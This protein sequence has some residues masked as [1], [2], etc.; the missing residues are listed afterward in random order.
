M[1]SEKINSLAQSLLGLPAEIQEKQIELLGLNERIST[2]REEISRT[3]VSIKSGI[4]QET[5]ING[6][7]IY[8][9]EDARAA[10]FIQVTEDNEELQEKKEEFSTLQKNYS[11]LSLEIERLQRDQK[12]YRVLLDF[13]KS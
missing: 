8:S 11:L 6:K 12:N 13:F 7:K 9:N 2:L 4:A 3:E 1:N 5:D 10:A